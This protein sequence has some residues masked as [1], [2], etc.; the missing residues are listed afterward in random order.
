MRGIE[1]YPNAAPLPHCLQGRLVAAQHQPT[2]ASGSRIT[3]ITISDFGDDLSE[4][5]I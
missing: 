4:T 5:T 2:L 1:A 3:L